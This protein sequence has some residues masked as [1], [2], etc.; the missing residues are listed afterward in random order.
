MY[1][2]LTTR[3]RRPTAIASVT[4]VMLAIALLMPQALAN[5]GNQRLEVTPEVSS[6]QQGSQRAL[7]AT[8]YQGD[9]NTTGGANNST[10]PI[11]VDFV[12]ESGPN[13]GETYA[14]TI[15]VGNS[16]C[17][18]SYQGD[19]GVG[20]DAVRATVRG[21]NADQA[22]GRYAGPTDCPVPPDPNQPNSTSP[23]QESDCAA[24]TA[25][26]GNNA[27]NQ[28]DPTDVVEVNWTQNVSGNVCIDAEPNSDTN[29]S[30]SS[31]EIQ[32]RATDGQK[33]SD[34]SGQF[35]CSGIAR[36]GILLDLELTDDDPNAFFETVNGQT[37]SPSG[38][39]PNR[40][41]CT[42]GSDGVCRATIRTVAPNAE[43]TN[44][45]TA[46]VRGT[47][48]G[49]AFPAD[50]QE[51]VEKT[52]RRPG[53]LTE[54]DATP[55]ADTNE[56]GTQHLVS[57]RAIDEFGN[58]V[59]GVIVS[60]QVTAGPH[61]N[62]D[63]DN[64]PNTPV[65]YFG[66]CT[67]GN[68]G[69][70]SQ[71]YTGTETGE[72]TI[73]VFEDDD[74]DFRYDMSVGGVGG[75]QPADQVSKNWVAAGQG[76]QR[77]RLDMETDA[78]NNSV[79]ENGDC[80]GDRQP[81]I[82]E[83]GW[84]DRSAPN[85][86]ARNSAHKICAERFGANDTA[87]V[88]PVTFRITSGPGHFTDSTGRSDLGREVTVSDDAQGYNVTYLSS[89][90]TG[91]TVVEAVAS[92]A[93]DTGTAPWTAAPGTARIIDLEPED[94][95]NPSGT[96]HEVTATV[97]DKFG[98]PVRG[99]QVTFTEEGAGRF[100][101]GGSSA[102]RTT[103]PEGRASARTTSADNET[104]DQQI[105]ASIDPNNTE[106][107]R[108]AGT[109]DNEDPA[110]VCGDTVANRWETDD[111]EPPPP[112]EPEQCEKPGVICGDDEDNVIDGTE[113]DDVIYTFGGN[114]TV[115]GHGGNDVIYLG[116][117]NDVAFGGDGDDVIRGGKGRD[118]LRGQS[119][120]DVL[121]GQR[122]HDTIIGADGNDI[123]RGSKGFDAIRGNRG[124]DDIRGGQRNDTLWGGRGHDRIGGGNGND[125][126][127]GNRGFDTLNGSRGIDSCRGGPGPDRTRN[128]EG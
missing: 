101:E 42:T 13:Q 93:R 99:V 17:S 65:G 82:N 64:D 51:A 123:M 108:A 114:D 59:A 21:D 9:T 4:S 53:Q 12:I 80:D 32:V 91:D 36:A 122:G 6:G 84:N 117:G 10:G 87:Q 112:P 8:L 85:Q 103:G 57:A 7:T 90:Q 69:T 125:R 94:D 75:D 118:T 45:V 3:P 55:E 79:D 81:P 56:I 1:V 78:N 102:T 29:P 104:G 105:T 49:D 40:V 30:G 54:I 126:L 86:V 115:D 106:C 34:T 23:R 43:G 48:S 50:N 109:P 2:R 113:G 107:D 72:D 26:P 44:E 24:G 77:V 22:E 98:N 18:I 119:G 61:S 71:G 96:E 58:T 63:L 28:A 38:G 73:T 39:G 95:T 100:V 20:T 14:C 11:V 66:R 16:N 5:H 19:E 127:F 37:T 67:T 25:Q 68:D 116:P 121:N 31:H 52:W 74:S 89:T 76:T 33:V 15:V 111:P 47:G 83:Q 97:T 110:G 41:T 92:G 124:T 35:D 88:G 70:C 46:A 62:N 120:D 27:E 128:C 60:F